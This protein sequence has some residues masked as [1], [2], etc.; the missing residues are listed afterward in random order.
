MALF[1]DDREAPDLDC[2]VVRTDVSALSLH[3]PRQWAACWLSLTLWDRLE[4][5]PFCGPR[6]PVSRQGRRRLDV[7]KT[8]VC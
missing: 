1:A 4:L 5:D 6:L 2:E 7:L 3:R 8:Q